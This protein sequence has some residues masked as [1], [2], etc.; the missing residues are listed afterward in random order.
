MGELNAV[1]APG[2]MMMF[3]QRAV[4]RAV[5]TRPW[6]LMISTLPVLV[7]DFHLMMNSHFMA[8]ET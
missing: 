5:C 3:Q 1:M 8:V 4:Q 6:N 2:D 7:P